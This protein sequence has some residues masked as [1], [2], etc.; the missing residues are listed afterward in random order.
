MIVLMGEVPPDIAGG[1]RG[2][3]R[4]KVVNVGFRSKRNI[5]R[6]Y[7]AMDSKMFVVGAILNGRGIVHVHWCRGRNAVAW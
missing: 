7:I 6:K 1:R 2:H 5:C 3:A 4:K